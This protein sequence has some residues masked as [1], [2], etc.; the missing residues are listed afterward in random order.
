VIALD[1]EVIGTSFF[2]HSPAGYCSCDIA[3]LVAYNRTL[4]ASEIGL[5]EGWLEHRFFGTFGNSG[6]FAFVG[7]NGTGSSYASTLQIEASN[8]GVT[9]SD[10]PYLFSPPSP[11][12]PGAADTPAG[13]IRDPDV[14]YW[15]GQWVAGMT[16]CGSPC[17]TFTVFTSSFGG[18]WQWAANVTCG[19]YTGSP[20]CWAPG[21]FVDSAGLLHMI[22]GWDSSGGSDHV[23]YETHPTGSTASGSWSPGVALSNSS[24]WPVDV[25][26]AYIWQEGSTFEM[27]AKDD[28]TKYVDYFTA[29]ALTGPWTAKGTGNWAGWGQYFEGPIHIRIDNGVRRVYLDGYTNHTPTSYYYSNGSACSTPGDLTSCTWSPPA[30]IT[31]A[32]VYGGGYLEH[33]TIIRTSG[34]GSAVQ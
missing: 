4:S 9:F 32:A 29:S 18:L 19:S 33:G 5:V 23:L 12:Q 28:T 11:A 26:D 27:L 14:A 1:N 30:A 7:F 6:K 16:S 21:A 20:T 2:A 31:A 3:Y 8:D 13:D 22:Y 15:A 34:A 17:N 25:I 24:T 10:A